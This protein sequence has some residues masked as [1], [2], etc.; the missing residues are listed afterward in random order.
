[1]DSQIRQAEREGSEA[2]MLVSRLRLG[3]LDP[4]NVQLTAR[5]GHPPAME[6]TGIEENRDA[7]ASQS[8]S[9]ER[10]YLYADILETSMPRWELEGYGYKQWIAHV[11]SRYDYQKHAT[12]FESPYW[13]YVV[14]NTES[15]WGTPGLF[16]KQLIQVMRYDME[17]Q[18][19]YQLCRA[20][21]NLCERIFIGAY[22]M[23]VSPGLLHRPE[24]ILLQTCYDNGYMHPDSLRS[25]RKRHDTTPERTIKWLLK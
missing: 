24:A 21:K 13:S 3:N 16:S 23:P 8:K 2:D 22:H 15:D 14:A 17:K 11:P 1:M 18:G 10:M 19:I 25:L 12:V 6:V 5:L 4:R 20:V 7:F 9:K